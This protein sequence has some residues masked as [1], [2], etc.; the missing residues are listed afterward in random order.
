SVH[1]SAPTSPPHSFPTR[2]SSDPVQVTPPSPEVNVPSVPFGAVTSAL[3][4]L[5]TASENVIV[6]VAVSPILSAVSDSVTEE[7]VGAWVSML[8][9]HPSQPEPPS[10]V[11]SVYLPA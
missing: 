7:T 6:T 8:E 3:L 10:Q 11:T 2:R 1:A 4:K 9:L 5:L